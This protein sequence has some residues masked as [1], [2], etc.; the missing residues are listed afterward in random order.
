MSK[1]IGT[2]DI[3]EKPLNGQPEEKKFNIQKGKLQDPQRA[4][5]YGP[6]GIG[7]STLSS[8]FPK[9]LF[10]DWE[11]STSD[12]DVDRIT[13]DDYEEGKKIL[14]DLRQNPLGYKTLIIDTIDWV[15]VRMAQY[16]SEENK[17]DS[18][19]EIGY[20][21][22]Y[23]MLADEMFRFVTFLRHFTEDQKMNVVLCSHAAINPME[24]PDQ[25]GSY[26]FYTLDL[27]KKVLPTV[28]EWATMILFINW[29]MKLVNKDAD[30]KGKD[31][32][33]KG[34]GGEH[35]IIFTEHRAAFDAKNRKGLPPQ[36]EWK[37]L[38]TFP[39]A[40]LF[41]AKA[42]KITAFNQEESIEEKTEE[43]P[44]EKTLLEKVKDAEAFLK[45][46]KVQ[47]FIKGEPS[48]QRWN[49]TD[50][51]ILEDMNEADLIKWLGHL[52]NVARK[53][54]LFEEEPA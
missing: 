1:P 9:P 3:P 20:N 5:I 40:A 33:K 30:T 24:L 34:V 37:T 47:H 10:L 23:E 54:G 6:E 35:R 36:I 31:P 15:E 26:N 29:Q 21:R 7:K 45:E 2:F 25:Q 43:A 14:N 4:V 39:L 46:N 38:N 48:V 28:K 52:E 32:K 19:A 11:G 8:M 18:L 53:A 17:V 51:R 42:E 16:I 13:V 50:K 27:H 49:I 22:G 12:L 44:V 41:D